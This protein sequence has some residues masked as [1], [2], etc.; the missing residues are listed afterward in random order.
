MTTLN[1][2]VVGVG[3]T[4]SRVLERCK[5]ARGFTRSPAPSFAERTKLL[6][7][8][9]PITH[10]LSLPQQYSLLYT[11]EPAAQATPDPRLT[12]LLAAL[13]P[14]P[15]RF[16]LISTSGI[17]GDCGG[18]LVNENHLP[19][20]Q[21]ARAARRVAAE[22]QVTEWAKR[23][24]VSLC[25]LRVPGIYGPGRLGLDR[26]ENA[27]PAIRE[28]DAF[29][30][31]RIHVDDLVSCCI[32]ALDPTIPAGIYNVSDG[33][34]RSST[35]FSA[36]VARQAGFAPPPVISR[37]EAQKAFSPL[38]YSF[39]CESRRLDTS[40]MRDLLGV[41]PMYGNPADGIRASLVDEGLNPQ[42]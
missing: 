29:P 37:R 33:D 7:L 5:T 27:A 34:H 26:L 21:S 23:N 3:Y 12:H 24:G 39:F 4:G 10:S 28:E 30:G 25:I 35:W 20:P 32:A 40:R 19:Q 13:S 1:Q 18:K 42:G 41:K 38:R 36:E 31:N 2:I 14:L 22:K 17:Y 9:K 8:D 15:Q 11:V 16:V 6:D